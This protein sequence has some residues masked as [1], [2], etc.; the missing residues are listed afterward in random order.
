MIVDPETEEKM[1]VVSGAVVVN[2]PVPPAGLTG[3]VH[4]IARDRSGCVD[5]CSRHFGCNGCREARPAGRLLIE[6]AVAV[7]EL[8]G[9]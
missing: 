8:L 1:S 4:T 6:D 9:S 5:G 2:P 7:V 3:F